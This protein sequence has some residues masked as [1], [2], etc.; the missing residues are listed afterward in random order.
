MSLN[1]LFILFVIYCVVGLSLSCSTQEGKEMKFTGAKGEVQL[2]T[3]DPGHFHAALVQKIMYDQ[4]SPVVHVYAPAGADVEDHLS[5][6][7]GFNNRAENPTAWQEKVYTGP[8]FL[9][10]MIKEKRGNVVVISGNNARKTEYILKS[11]DAGLNVLADKPMCI[12]KAGFARLKDAFALAEKNHLLLYDIMTERSEITTVLQK[13]LALMPTVFGTLEKGSLE[14]PAVT[15]ESVHHFFKYVAGNPIKRPAWFFD[16]SQ[17]GEGLVDVTT[18][19]VDLVQWE[20]FPAQIIDYSQDIEL[21][22]A[23]RWPTMLSREQSA[24]VTGLADFPDYLSAQ[25]NGDG[26]LPVYS[27]GE[28]DYSVKGVHAKVSV[29]WKFQAPE[30]AGDTHFSIMRGSKASLIIRQGQ[31]QNYLPELYVEAREGG[32]ADELAVALADALVELQQEYPGIDLRKEGE[33]WRVLIPDSYR[34]GHEAHFGEVTERF[35]HYLVDGKLPEWEVPN[36]LAKYYLTT[37]ALEL[38]KKQGVPEANQ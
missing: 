30:G 1:R 22:A 16:T 3:L 29:V 8:D 24:K 27:N 5:R 21:L 9:E 34:L 6:V 36:M 4:V 33:N 17:Q 31:E 2:I 12:D 23:K 19:L 13:E 35:L 11:V 25:L 20:C 38:A 14:N 10:K 37:T 18:H 32:N 15:K 28:I 26:Q 7:E